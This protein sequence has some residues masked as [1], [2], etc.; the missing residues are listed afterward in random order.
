MEALD[1]TKA[2]P[3]SP[4]L[5]IGGL[6]MLAR[7]IDKVRATLPGGN[8][9]DYQIDGF[10]RHLWKALGLDASGFIE[11]VTAA[12]CDDDVV[13]WVRNHSDQAIY[14]EVN[15]KLT[16]RTVGDRIEDP[17]FVAKYPIASTLPHDTRLLD[18]LEAD[19]RAVF[20][21]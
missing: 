9:G 21:K 11:A 15:E 2:P 8:L 7:T 1:L 20:A 19:D 3:R 6:L 5:E 10:S 14:P 16:A 13:A 12:K 18:M 17:E 4:N